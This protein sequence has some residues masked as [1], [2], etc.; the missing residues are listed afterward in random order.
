MKKINH[1][2]R[3]GRS[4]FTLIESLVVIAI[5]AILAAMLLPAL[6]KA[7]SKAKASSCLANLK[8]L[9]AAAAMYLGDNKDEIMY[10]GMMFRETRADGGKTNP[11]GAA[12]RNHN[13]S[14]DDYLNVYIGGTFTE[15]DKR[16][17]F[18]SARSGLHAGRGRTVK[19]LNCPANK[20]NIYPNATQTRQARARRAYNP[21][22]HRRGYE[23]IGNRRGVIADDWPPSPKNKTGLGLALNGRGGADLSRPGPAGNTAW[24]TIENGNGNAPPRRQMAVNMNIVLDQV[25]TILLTENISDENVAGRAQNGNCNFNNINNH[26]ENWPGRI[27]KNREAQ[28]FH[29]GRW[30]YLFADMHVEFLEPRATLGLGTRGADQTGG[31]SILAGD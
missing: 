11:P 31:W 14:W 30:N 16:R 2:M 6:A 1:R 3:S 18:V 24:N 29:M 20:I 27:N 17:Q 12:N 25:D 13:Y 19:M 23:N 7:R 4:G 10:A 5:I 9:G 15:A 8:N 28:L 22:K 21:P 26:L